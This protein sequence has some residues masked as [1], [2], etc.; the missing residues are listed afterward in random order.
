MFTNIKAAIFDLD[1]TLV[2]SMNVW[3]NID[4]NFLVKRGI[5]A[6]DDLFEHTAPLNAIAKAAYFKENYDINDSIEDIVNEFIDMGYKEYSANVRLK[7]GAKEY[8]DHLKSKG[9][10]LS[11]A[12]GN[13]P[14][15]VEAALKSNDIYN[16]FDLVVTSDEVNNG[17]DK[18]DIYLHSAKKLKVQPDE[19]IVFDDIL[20]AVLGAKL[21]GMK[22]IAVYDKYAEH[23]I[24]DIKRNAD[25][26]VYNFDEL[27][28]GKFCD[29]DK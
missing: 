28:K 7:D 9:I 10:K 11:I 24:E 26:F 13:T 27:L 19:C 6:P 8:L 18:P 21:A 20:P 14:R 29:G 25:H 17:K 16:Y 23:Q 12:T 22:V 15:L 1:G 2:E 3:G 5:P 4:V